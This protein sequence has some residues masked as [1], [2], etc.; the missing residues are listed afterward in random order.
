MLWPEY[1]LSP[2]YYSDVGILTP[3]VMILG[4]GLLGGDE[5]MKA[6]PL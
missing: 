6:E 4:G 3:K 2:P 5:V 1:L